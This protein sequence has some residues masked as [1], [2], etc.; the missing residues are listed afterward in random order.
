MP[1]HVGTDLEPNTPELDVEVQKPARAILQVEFTR[2]ELALLRR[3]I[4][5]GPGMAR[6]VKLAALEAAGGVAK[7]KSGD[8]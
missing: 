5:Q 7:G 6:F 1:I 4:G 8:G 3:A 2:E